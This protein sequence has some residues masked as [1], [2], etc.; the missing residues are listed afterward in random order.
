MVQ[1][2]HDVLNLGTGDAAGKQQCCQK[3]AGVGATG[4]DVVGIDEHRIMS[5]GICGKGDGIGL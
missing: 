2:V 1:P 5:D 3:P 4:C